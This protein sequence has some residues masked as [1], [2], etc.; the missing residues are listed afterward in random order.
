[1]FSRPGNPSTFKVT[2]EADYD[3]KD[4]RGL[5]DKPPVI[6]VLGVGIHA[7]AHLSD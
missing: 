3:E 4:C 5:R 2:F 6:D 7:A 1:V